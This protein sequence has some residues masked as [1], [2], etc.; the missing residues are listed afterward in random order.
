MH[1]RRTLLV[2]LCV[3]LCRASATMQDVP[4]PAFAKEGELA[5]LSPEGNLRVKIDIEI[6]ET[7]AD[8]ARGLMYRE[9]M[10][11]AQGMLFVFAREDEKTFWMKNTQI[12]LDMLFVD[13]SG[14]IVTICRNTVPFSEEPYS[15]GAKV[16]YVLEVNA[17]AADRWRISPG[18]RV[19][20]QRM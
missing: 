4:P 20:W 7:A 11:A 19:Y 3:S 12:P 16:K 10:E 2:V 5:V 9:S 17:G 14:R 15:S 1:F 18:D 13:A 8:Q 6:A